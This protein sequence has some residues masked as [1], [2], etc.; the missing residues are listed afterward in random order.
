M[1]FFQRQ[2]HTES[3]QSLLRCFIEGIDRPEIRNAFELMGSNDFYHAAHSE[4][5]NAIA[6]TIEQGTEVDI[7]SIMSSLPEQRNTLLAIEENA[8]GAFAN[9]AVYARIVKEKQ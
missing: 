3:E 9:V 7:V 1:N 4:I 6:K 2:F 5:F 8:I